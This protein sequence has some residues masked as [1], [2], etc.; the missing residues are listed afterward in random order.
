LRREPARGIEASTRVLKRC[1]RRRPTGDILPAHRFVQRLRRRRRPAQRAQRVD[2]RQSLNRGG[3][4]T[5]RSC[6]AGRASS[7]S[8]LLLEISPA[9]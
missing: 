9:R 3:R 4:F 7:D 8:A 6:V 5:G 2:R 1:D